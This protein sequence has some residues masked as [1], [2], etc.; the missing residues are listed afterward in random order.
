MTPSNKFAI[1]TGLPE[2][3]ERANIFNVNIDDVITY[4][5]KGYWVFSAVIGT[6]QTMIQVIDLICENTINGVN[7]YI[8]RNQNSTTKCLL[9]PSRRIFKVRNINR[10]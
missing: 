5:V 8:N 6:T 3:G 10:L 1:M 2:Y 4:K 9:K 7:L